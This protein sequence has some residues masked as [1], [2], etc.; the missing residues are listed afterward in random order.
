M[1]AALSAALASEPDWPTTL[2]IFTLPVDVIRLIASPDFALVPAEGEVSTTNPCGTVDESSG[3]DVPTLSPTAFSWAVAAATLSPA[4]L[5]TLS[6]V[7]PLDTVTVT[8]ECGPTE[9]P[10]AGVV[11]MTAPGAIVELGT[12]CSTALSVSFLSA[13][14]ASSKDCPA[15]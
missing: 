11:L 15:S 3:V 13:V 7:G 2:G 10:A 5:G 14:D 8:S 4:T 12:C 1:C 9:L 6:A